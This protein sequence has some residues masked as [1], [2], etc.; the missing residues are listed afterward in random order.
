[1]RMLKLIARGF[2]AI[3]FVAVSMH[4]GSAQTPAIDCTQEPN[5][6][7]VGVEVWR[8]SQPRLLGRS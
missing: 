5:L 8:I 3:A 6:H 7:L 2:F 1:M 4:A